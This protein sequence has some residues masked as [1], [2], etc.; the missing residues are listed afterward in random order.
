[1]NGQTL[2]DLLLEFAP[3][4]L[5][6]IGGGQSVLADVQRAVVDRHHWLTHGQFLDD[7]AISRASPGPNLLMI[8][9]IGWQIGG[10]GGA[11]AA[12]VGMFL[13]SSIL[14]YLAARLWHRHSGSRWHVILSKGLTPIAAGLVLAGPFSVLRASEAG[15]WGWGLALLSML[16]LVATK[17]H[18]LIVLAAGATLFDLADRLGWQI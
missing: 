18:P 9:L 4:S 15:P 13:P 8:P 12:A 6:S 17:I 1:M 7:F 11:V 16:V 10:L 2:L 5:L 3:L 14:F